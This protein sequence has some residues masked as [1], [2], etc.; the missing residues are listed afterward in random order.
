MTSRLSTKLFAVAR[1]IGRRA[2]VALSKNGKE[3]IFNRLI[4]IIKSLGAAPVEWSR[5]WVIKTC[6]KAPCLFAFTWRRYK[7]QEVLIPS[8]N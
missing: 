1:I 3:V 4:C 6:G 5:V 7:Y 2:M 8:G